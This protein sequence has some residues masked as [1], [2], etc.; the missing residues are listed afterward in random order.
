ME[1]EKEPR[2]VGMVWLDGL[3]CLVHSCECNLTEP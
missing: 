2:G 3:G 1:E